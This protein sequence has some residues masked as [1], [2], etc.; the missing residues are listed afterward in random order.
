MLGIQK[1]FTNSFYAILSLPATAMGF[2]LS[3][4]IS[5]LSWILST[6]YNLRIDEVGFVWAAGPLAGI[7][8]QVIIG[9]ISDKVWLWGGRR[10]PFILIGGLLASVMLLALPNIH[11]IG[12]MLGAKSLLLIATV[13]ALTL[14][15]AINISFNPTRSVIADVTPEGN[16]RTKGYTWMQTISGFFGVLAYVVGAIFGNYALIYAGIGVVLLFSILPI[17][18]ITEPKNVA[19][20]KKTEET[21]KAETSSKP[22]AGT[23]QLFKIYFA[24]GFTWLGVQTMFIY[25]IAYIQQKLAPASENETGQIIAI[26][27][28]ILNTVGFILPAF[29]LEPLSEKMGRIRTHISCV[30]IMALGYFGIVAFGK[31]VVMLYVLMAILGI[32]WSAVV[33]LPFAIYSEKVNKN[34]MGFYMGIFNLS[35]VIPQLFASYGSGYVIQNSPDKNVIFIISGVSL[36]VSALLWFFV[37]EEEKSEKKAEELAAESR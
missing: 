17:L 12:A 10:R 7:L 23:G 14:D 19:E 11:I 24:H 27:F 26:S 8:G 36:T 9:I 25:I 21:A 15:L 4:Q 18:F 34:R 30:A 5:A 3:I 6:K 2:A 35:V 16:A 31:S 29:V 20:E 32:G 1:R 33:S 13:V 28:A 37:K 22:A